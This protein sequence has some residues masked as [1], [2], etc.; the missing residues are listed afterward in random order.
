MIKKI[1][2]SLIILS[3]FE[4]KA[5]VG[6]NT[7]TPK[8][9]LEIKSSNEA[10][11]A[12]TDGLLI[13]KINAFPV[14]NP[15]AD[16]QG[17]LVYL[18]TTVGANTPGFYFW[19]NPTTAWL[20]VKG[21]DGGTLDQAYDFGGA[22]NGRTITAD[23][24][25]V[26]IAGTDGLVSTGISGSGALA[27]S[28]A[29]T[30]MVWNPRKAA[31]RAGGVSGT[32]WDDANIGSGSVAFSGGTASGS[33]SFAGAGSTASATNSF[34]G[35]G[36]TA[37]GQSSVAFGQGTVVNS[38]DSIAAGFFC[39]TSSSRSVAFG[40]VNTASG[41]SS[42]VFGENSTAS[43]GTA[44]AFGN[45]NVASGNI[46]TAFGR[47]NTAFSYGETVL[48]IGA[49]TYT[50]STNGATQFRAAN[51]T[52]RLFVIGNAID[53][54]NDNTVD[55]AERSDAMV[56]LKNGS[57]GIGTSTPNALLDVASNNKGV[58]VPRVSLTSANVASPI[59]NPNGGALPEST[60]VYNTSTA[61][62]GANEVTPGFHYWNGTK[63]VKLEENNGKTKYYTAIGTFDTGVGSTKTPMS[64][65]QITF[66]PKSSVVLVNFS[67]SGNNTSP[68][69]FSDFQSVV[70]F[71]L[72][73][74]GSLVKG[75]QTSEVNTDESVDRTTWDTNILYP[76]TVTPFVTQTISINWAS[77]TN[78]A[79]NT[80]T[81]TSIPSSSLTLNSHRVLSVIDPEGGGGIV[82]PITPPVTNQF[83]SIN[84][85]S[86]TSPTTNFMGTMDNTDLVFKR[87]NIPSGR[88][89][90]TNTFFGL[91]SGSV[92]AASNN[93]YLGAL[94]GRDNV[95]GQENVFIG[96][97][98]GA[99]G[100]TGSNN[101]LIGNGAGISNIANQNTFLG[102][103]S[104][105]SNST[106]GNNSFFGYS[107]GSFTSTGLRNTFL[108]AFAGNVNTIGTDNTMIGT[109]ANLSSDSLNNATAIGASA[110]VGASNSLV[111]GSINGVNSA[112]AT[113]NV[114]I[115][116][117]T[118]Q[119]RLHVAGK[120]FLTDGFS[121]DNAALIYRNNT[122][123]MF[124]GPQSGSSS[125]GAAMALYGS[126]N[127]AG[128][129]AGGVDFNVPGSQVRMNHTNGSYT[130]RANSTSGYAATFEINDTG[131]EITHNSASRAFVFSPNSTERMRLTP[132]GFLGI[133]TT[134]PARKLHVSNGVSGGTSNANTGILLESSG[135][136]Y[137]HYLAPSASESG[138]L[139]GSEVA[140]IN[141]G[142][143]FN[144]SLATSGIQFRAGGNVNR[145]TITS[146]GDIGIGTSA[147]GGQ[148]ELSLNEGR[149]PTS[150]TWT[151]PSDAR[152]KNVD[153]IYQKGLTE[154]LQLKPIRYHYKNTD[155]KSFESEVLEKEAYGFLA[156]EVQQIF[157]EAVGTDADGYL[158][159]DLHPIL[160]AY[161]NAFKELNVKNKAVEDKNRELEQKLKSQEQII[162]NLIE[163]LEKL[164][165]KN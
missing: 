140:S 127:T 14:T 66:T 65:M 94:A 75:F 98:A 99:L 106:G 74:N 12:N 47:N 51:A 95:T 83:W 15:T 50:P 42:T 160:V 55:L 18:T 112:T 38:V 69:T 78:G 49:T 91:S 113:V 31:F 13:P 72:L 111:L 48:G 46:A 101:V 28:G 71:D 121:A 60:L 147:P 34:A 154:I 110:Q 25:A 153:G 126:T 5:Q 77:R 130:F 150:N 79:F 104:G 68:G 120:A 8:A 131:L 100:T 161:A 141:G 43:G 61:G 159:F 3:G 39:T 117:T 9:Q 6:I 59:I 56:V 146:A 144:N 63:W 58:M 73:L 157:P 96:R 86:G 16:Q 118:P 53:A 162:N 64:Q 149:K 107:S 30:R 41:S 123:Y 108:G 1:L 20:P 29:G 54:D 135:S 57:T 105:N 40:S 143:I 152:L 88:I 133:G 82:T 93:T 142:I 85:N 4:S 87:F 27:P 23:A 124:L 33:S 92:S 11:P 102:S 116:T 36:G 158:N 136:V 52:D 37:N 138:M 137:Q 145:M 21:T 90:T 10:T 76:V 148:F 19:N 114:G 44:T 156:Q 62:I 119:E 122:D 165:A 22:G 24:G 81:P 2:L 7:T 109:S 67:A 129:N 155:K 125:N 151:I 32:Q 139:F 84:G 17:M 164:E 80:L 132:G 103:F 70:F 134:A 26:T 163:R 35:A 45:S 128:G 97:G 115:G 89:S